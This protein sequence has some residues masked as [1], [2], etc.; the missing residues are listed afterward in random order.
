[1]QQSGISCQRSSL[2]AELFLILPILPFQQ[3]RH[4]SQPVD[5]KDVLHP[6][7]SIKRK[8]HSTSNSI[9]TMSDKMGDKLKEIHNKRTRSK[10]PKCRSFHLPRSLQCLGYQARIWRR[11]GSVGDYSVAKLSSANNK[12]RTTFGCNETRVETSIFA[13]ADSTINR[14]LQYLGSKN[15]QKQTATSAPLLGTGTTE[16]KNRTYKEDGENRT[17]SWKLN[18]APCSLHRLDISPTRWL[19][20]RVQAVTRSTC[21]LTK[22]GLPDLVITGAE[23]EKM[24]DHLISTIAPMEQGNAGTRKVLG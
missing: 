6:N 10:S 1:M 9:H 16:I 21:Y 3:L 13:D 8:S 18:K 12:A 17:A 22:S 24:E 14:E 15:T 20:E 5:S 7:D 11:N 2:P 19:R 4:R 23:P